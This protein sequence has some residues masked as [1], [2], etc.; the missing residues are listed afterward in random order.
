MDTNRDEYNK[1]GLIAFVFSVAFCLLFFVYIAFIQPGVDLKE[2]PEETA[3]PGQTVATQAEVDPDISKIAK[4]WEE[5]A[6]MAMHGKFVYK[7]TCAVC[8]GDKGLGDGPAGLALKPPPRNFVEGKWKRG[9]DSISLYTT[10]QKGL[11]GTLMVSFKQLPK[12][13]RWALVQFVRSLTKNKT[14]D[15]AAKLAAFAATAD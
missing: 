4:P 8:H 14:P 1:G 15:D 10:L 2:V 7:N 5:N 12:A 11:E 3:A 13:D 6:D 9:G